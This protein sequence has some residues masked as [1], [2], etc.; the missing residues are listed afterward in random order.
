MVVLQQGDA[1]TT[2]LPFRS[3]SDVDAKLKIVRERIKKLTFLTQ[4]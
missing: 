3:I 1:Y 4:I 2:F